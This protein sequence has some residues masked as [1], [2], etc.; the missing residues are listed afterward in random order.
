MTYLSTQKFKYLPHS[1]V[2]NRALS[3]H[4]STES[5]HLL[6]FI[7]PL[8]KTCKKFG[9]FDD[10]LKSDSVADKFIEEFAASGSLSLKDFLEYDEKKR[11]RERK[12]IKPKIKAATDFS[13][14]RDMQ[15]MQDGKKTKRCEDLKLFDFNGTDFKEVRSIDTETGELLTFKVKGKGK[16]RKFI[17]QSSRSK[18][19]DRLS[20]Q[21]VMAKLFP[22]YR[23][24]KCGCV[25]QSNSKGVGV[26]KSKKHKTISCSNLQTCSSVWLDPVCAA[27]ITEKRRLEVKQAIEKH[28][29]NGGSISLVTR[30]VPHTKNDSLVSLR[31]RFREADAYM[32]E[33]YQY[34][35]MRPRFNVDGD[36]KVF[37]I[38]VTWL[39]GWHLH[40][41][42]VYFHDTD[43]FEGEALESNPAYVAFLKDFEQ[44]Y[45]DVW[46][47]SATKAGFDE[48]SREYGLQVQNGDF[49]AEYIAKWGK[50]PESNWG[51]D[52]ELTKAH[53]K[54]SKKGYTPWELI[55]LYRDTGDERLVP[56]I[57]EYGH[58]MFGQQQLIWSKGLKKKFGI[59]EKS[60]EELAE[61]LEDTAEEI[62]VLSPVQWKFIVKNDLKADFFH[63]AVQGW[64]VVTDYLHSFDKYPKIFS[65]E[66]IPKNS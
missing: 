17:L 59:G 55:R 32:K 29:E 65:L 34:K 7:A 5:T 35:K 46:R 14:L 60:D 28:Q 18:L 31:D 38:T 53:I 1:A 16:K 50:E 25:V 64:D 61:A 62:G 37:E 15:K 39:N 42:E 11:K 30:T 3:A 20:M 8:V 27:K 26:F 21:K 47:N 41:H 13:V 66:A 22:E 45:Y 19:D 33:N 40:I 57:Q 63:F 43:A 24:S 10:S 36:I 4:E 6:A 51:I 2:I 48:P 23:V 44:T 9:D 49:A 58:S 56:I 52:A 54:S 12:R